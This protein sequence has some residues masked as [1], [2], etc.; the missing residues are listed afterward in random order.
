MVVWVKPWENYKEVQW[1][2]VDCPSAKN[3][4]VSGF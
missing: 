4:I 3:R 1:D 2:Q